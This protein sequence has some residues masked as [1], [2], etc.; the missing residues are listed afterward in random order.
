MLDEARIVPLPSPKSSGIVG[1][2]EGEGGGGEGEGGGGE[3]GSGEGGGG[4]EVAAAPNWTS[5][6]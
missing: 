4:E 5:R 6:R 3:G 1:G 2:G